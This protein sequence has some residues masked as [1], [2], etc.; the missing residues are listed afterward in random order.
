MQPPVGCAC[1]VP[2]GYGNTTHDALAWPG[3]GASMSF[4]VPPFNPGI[5]TWELEAYGSSSFCGAAPE[6]P[7]ELDSAEDTWRHDVQA[8]VSPLSHP[9]TRQMCSSKI[10]V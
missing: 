2:L 5:V 10:F 6:M 7:M 4:E 8:A 1:A 9:G 3:P